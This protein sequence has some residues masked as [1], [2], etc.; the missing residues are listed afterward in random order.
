[1]EGICGDRYSDLWCILG[2]RGLIHN[3]LLFSSQQTLS[4]SGIKRVTRDMYLK[5]WDRARVLFLLLPGELDN[6]GC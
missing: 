3:I 4:M 6:P 1:M 2:F 5:F